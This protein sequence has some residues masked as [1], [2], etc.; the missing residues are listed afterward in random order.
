LK[1]NKRKKCSLEKNF[2]KKTRRDE[3]NELIKSKK[4]ADK[5]LYAI[6]G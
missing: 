2:R 1:E 3:D 4:R 5:Y 6:V